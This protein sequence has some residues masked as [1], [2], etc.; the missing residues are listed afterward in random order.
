MRIAVVADPYIPVPPLHYGG[1]ERVIA[2]L[3]SG[4]VARGHRV[5]LWAAPG[6]RVGCEIVPYG[7]PPHVGTVRR[8][9]ELIQVAWPLWRRRHELDL[10]HSFGRLAAL[11]PVLPLRLPKVQSYQREI[12]LRS[13]RWGHRMA[14]GSL[15][16]TACSDALRRRASHLGRWV[17]VYNGV[18]AATYAFV[19]TVAPDAPLV[20]LGRIERIKGTHTAIA[21]ARGAGRRLVIA[22]NVPEAHRDYFERE[23]RPHID[24]RVVRYVG[25]VD[26]A[27]KN[28]LLGSAAALLMPVEWEEPFG[29]VMAEALACGTPVVGLRRGAVPEVVEDGV[30]GFACD[31]PEEMVGAVSRLHTLDRAACRARFERLF[32]DEAVV[33]SYLRLYHQEVGAWRGRVR[34]G[35]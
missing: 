29:I 16:F 23:V 34:S 31:T 35:G 14:R 22:G 33:G 4:L 19:P 21:V 8:F 18:P 10:V 24:N 12:T 15:V 11:F 17:T 20:F 32:S 1:I 30:T 5:T 7:V 25:P 3:V 9:R 26:D 28:A 27:A 2:M 6:S 13:V